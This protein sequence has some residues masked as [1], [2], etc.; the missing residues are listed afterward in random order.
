MADR[1]WVVTSLQ[2]TDD[3]IKVLETKAYAA[4]EEAFRNAITQMETMVPQN[5][6]SR[7]SPQAPEERYSILRGMISDPDRDV[8]VSEAPL[9]LPL[10]VPFTGASRVSRPMSPTRSSMSPTRPMSPTG[11]TTRTSAP[12][13]MTRAT[14]PTPVSVRNS[15]ITRTSPVAEPMAPRSSRVAPTTTR[16]TNRSPTGYP[17]TTGSPRSSASPATVRRLSFSE[18]TL[19]SPPRTPYQL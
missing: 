12:T 19:A 16:M 11:M 13:T 17:M 4:S 18:D 15:R 10:T 2:M 7:M 14:S 1:I 8:L 6:M 3:G 5:R 9:I